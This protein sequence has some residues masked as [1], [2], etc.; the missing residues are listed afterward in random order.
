MP[1]G[2][3]VTILPRYTCKI[4][5]LSNWQL[6]CKVSHRHALQN[7]KTPTW[8][9]FLFWWKTINNFITDEFDNFVELANNM[10]LFKENLRKNDPETYNLL[11]S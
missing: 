1:C 9:V 4:Y 10:K 8:G 11:V 6:R 2:A 7:K 3:I 5:C